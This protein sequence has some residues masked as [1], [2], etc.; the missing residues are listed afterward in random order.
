MGLEK[1]IRFASNAFKA[2]LLAGALALNFGC[3]DTRIT[4]NN[5]PVIKQ[6]GDETVREGRS[7]ELYLD[8]NISDKDGDPLTVTLVNSRGKIVNNIFQYN[9]P[10]DD[11]YTDDVYA[12]NFLVS[13]GKAETA[14]S[15]NLVQIDNKPPLISYIPDQTAKESEHF[16]L[17]LEDYISDE[18]GDPMTA[19]LVNSRGRINSN[20]Y[21]FFEFVNNRDYNY[22]DDSYIINFLVSDGVDS[23]AGSFN[24]LHLDNRLPVVGTIPAQIVREGEAFALN[25]NDYVSD[26]DGDPLQITSANNVGTI[27]DNWFHYTPQDSDFVDNEKTKTFYLSDGFNAN[28]LGSFTILEQDIGIST[29]TETLSSGLEAR[30]LDAAYDDESSIAVN[31]QDQVHIG[32]RNG[33]SST[34]SRK[35]LLANINGRWLR[36]HIGPFNSGRWNSIAIDNQDR[37]HISYSTTDRN[38]EDLMYCLLDNINISAGY[39]QNYADQGSSLGLF[40]NIYLDSNGKPHITYYDWRRDITKYATNV[41]GAWTNANDINGLSVNYMD[42]LAIDSNNK[43]HVAKGGSSLSYVNDVVGSWQSQTIDSTA[44]SATSMKMDGNGCIHIAYQINPSTGSKKQMYASNSGGSWQTATLEE[45]VN[46]PY[47][48]PAIATDGNRAGILFLENRSYSSYSGNSTGVLKFACNGTGSWRVYT[49]DNRDTCSANSLA[50][51]S[52]GRFHVSYVE[53]VQLK[54]LSF[55]E[56]ELGQ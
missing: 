35:T 8:Y 26:E 24:L 23:T 12:I 29:T 13:D 16:T 25:L 32:Y 44:C 34:S 53:N 52:N 50:V 22:T 18:D 41:S 38:D 40:N 7:I 30:I 42:S 21:D 45:Q 54:Y 43:F 9:D 14:G 39:N 48:N 31:N 5:P 47:E 55:T 20:I 10:A 33:I 51:D 19:T 6:I 27:V 3:G 28:V 56:S 17:N 15:F 49:L 36:N 4:P 1:I 46:Y 37:L 2:S 11:N